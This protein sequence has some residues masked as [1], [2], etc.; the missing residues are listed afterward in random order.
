MAASSAFPVLALLL[1]KN[2]FLTLLLVA[3]LIIVL[4]DVARLLVRPLN[5]LFFHLFRPLLRQ[6][7][8]SR[9]TGASYGLLGMLAAFVLFPSDVAILA[10]FFAALGDPAAAMAGIRAP[11]KRI[12]GK[13]PW[14]TAAMIGM[15]LGVIGA[16]HVTGQ[17]GFQWQAAVG[18][19]VAG[20]AELL[21][22]PTDD[23]LHV[24]LV[25]GSA[26]ALLGM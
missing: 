11:G 20:A 25:A 17:I 4:G 26:M 9:I 5:R 18:A 19:T 12:Y 15:G 10:V 14:G 3:T 21:P 23:N 13:S 7:E 24:P 6:R 2:P 1:D 16:L 22:L 8:E